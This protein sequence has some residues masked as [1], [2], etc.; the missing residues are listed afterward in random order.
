M[1]N[2]HLIDSTMETAKDLV[3]ER[4]QTGA[5][6]NDTD[7]TARSGRLQLSGAGAKIITEQPKRE[8]SDEP[9]VANAAP[10][11]AAELPP[12]EV[13]SALLKA[14]VDPDVHTTKADRYRGME[15]RWVLRDIAAGRLKLSPVD[16]ADLQTLIDLKIVELRDGIPH[17]TNSGVTAII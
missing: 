7:A 4:A 17:L 6:E 5:V 8:G 1:K 11:S 15:L 12:A 13:T 10:S 16:E 14:I 3:V 9:A 2:F